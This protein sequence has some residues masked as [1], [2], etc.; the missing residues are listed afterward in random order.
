MSAPAT[1]DPPAAPDPRI[2]AGDLVADIGAALFTARRAAGLTRAQVARQLGVSDVTL[3]ELE[4][5]RGNPTL[6]R[7][8]RYA[9]AYGVT[10]DVITRHPHPRARR[11]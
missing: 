8:A 6:A 2:V 10:L 3:L 1:D 5:G 4:H 11:G 9:A 7:L